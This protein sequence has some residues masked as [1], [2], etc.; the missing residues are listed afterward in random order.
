MESPRLLYFEY[1]L[2][3]KLSSWDDFHFLEDIF[4]NNETAFTFKPHSEPLY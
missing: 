3:I 2:P 4:P 1:Q